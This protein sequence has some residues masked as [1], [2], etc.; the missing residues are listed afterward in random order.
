MNLT[1]FPSCSRLA[2]KRLLSLI[3][4]ALL[5]GMSDATLAQITVS[6]NVHVSAS[7]P[8]QLQAEIILDADSTRPGRLMACSLIDDSR[9]SGNNSITGWG[10]IVYLTDDGGKTWTKTFEEYSLMDPTCA[11]GPD[12]SAYLEAFEL[13][14]D[15]MMRLYRSADGGK[16]WDQPSKVRVTDRPYLTVDKTGGKFNGR[17]YSHGQAGGSAGMDGGRGSSG[18]RLYASTDG[19]TFGDPIERQTVGS[20]RNLGSGNGVVLSDGTLVMLFGELKEY[21]NADDTSQIRDSTLV[22]SNGRLRMLTSSDGGRSLS[23]AT[24]ISDF[25]MHVYPWRPAAGFIP[26]VAADTSNGPFKDRLYVVWPDRRSGRDEIYLTYSSDKGRTWSKPMTLNDD[27]APLIARSGPDHFMPIVAV[28]KEGVVGVSWYDRRDH[29]DNAGWDVRF[30]ASL[31]GGDTWSPNIR[32]SEEANN[33]NSKNK[34][35]ITS[36][37]SRVSSPGGPASIDLWVNQM[38]VVGGD[39]TGLAAD[40]MGV[41]HLAWADNRT[42][43]VQIWSSAV[44]VKGTAM[45]NGDSVLASYNDVTSTVQLEMSEMVFDRLTGVLTLKARLKNTG[46][47]EVSGSMKV[48]VIQLGSDLGVAEII[49][50]ENG[51]KGPGAIWDFTETLKGRDLKP[52]EA[53]QFKDLRFRIFDIRGLPTTERLKLSLVKLDIRVL[54]QKKTTG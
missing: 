14:S 49:A 21:W 44:T 48:R 8:E 7:H 26:W 18:V 5:V 52:G 16:T 13:S 10:V 53:S 42:G 17:L 9:K 20:R 41:F 28:N 25:Y 4:L 12:G 19:R 34:W 31:D 38:M 33:F 6:R 45:L 27:R 51:A 24:T 32:I 23:T 1:A 15:R 43:I 22:S 30:T 29:A 3:L 40:S 11:Y 46:A 39:T 54:A 36:V 47:Q 35:P 37:P 50:A 2:I